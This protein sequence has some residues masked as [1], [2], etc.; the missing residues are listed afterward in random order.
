MLS[1]RAIDKIIEIDTND[2]E[3]SVYFSLNEFVNFRR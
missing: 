3:P 2:L 1:I